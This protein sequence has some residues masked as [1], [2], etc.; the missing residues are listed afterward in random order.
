M[1]NN[2][3]DISIDEFD[4]PC[5]MHE[6]SDGYKKTKERNKKKYLYNKS[7][8]VKI[9]SVAV[10]AAAIFIATPFVVNAASDGGFFER[11]WGITGK[12]NVEAHQELVYESEKDSWYYVEYPSRE[13][14]DT[15]PGAAEAL[16]G[17]CVEHLNILK[18][19]DGTT[20]TLL[21]AVR[22]DNSAVV[23]LTFE[24]EGGVDVLNYSQLDNESK[25]A[26]FSDEST[27]W[28]NIGDSGNMY[29]D[30]DRST[31]EKICCY[32]YVS[33]NAF[34]GSSLRMEIN[35]YPCTLG[36]RN[37]LSME[38]NG[39]E[40]IGAIESGK[41]TIYADIPCENRLEMVEFVNSDGGLIEISPISMNIDMNTGLG[42]TPEQAYDP[43]S[44]YKICITFND[45]S[46]YT[47]TEHNYRD[48]YTCDVP[49]DNTGYTCG[50]IN[51]EYLLV[52]NRLVDT[53]KIASITVNGIEYKR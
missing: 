5:E 45:G 53:G 36:E 39:D 4:A 32:Y 26:W 29:V 2:R 12:T 24:K 37:A 48:L 21:S 33:L 19:V 40:L 42:L 31:E 17:D 49:I 44:A 30:L 11:I 10:A 38:E 34:G 1:S 51:N 14:V 41:T 47:V 22:D 23:E 52:F 35:Q 27:F 20:I 46:T 50:S 9:T 15:D 43:Y 8:T 25:G 18:E 7:H 3:F 16:I 28:L 6:F 13:Y